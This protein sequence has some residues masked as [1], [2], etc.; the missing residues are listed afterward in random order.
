VTFISPPP[1]GV[2]LAVGKTEREEVGGCG[3][4]ESSWS[5]PCQ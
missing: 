3:R 1:V 2:E 5:P 4:D